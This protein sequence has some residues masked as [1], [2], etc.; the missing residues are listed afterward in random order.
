M[1]T[2]PDAVALLSK[3]HTE[4]VYRGRTMWVM[5]LVVLLGTL[6]LGCMRKPQN[7]Q[8]Q[9]PNVDLSTPL[10]DIRTAI[11]NQ[12]W[13]KAD[14]YSDAVLQRYG[15]D[16]EAILLVAQVAHFNH[17]LEQSADLLLRAVQLE[18]YRNESRVKQCVVALV[19]VGKLFDAIDLLDEAVRTQ[20]DQ[21]ETRRLLFDLCMGSEMR[22]RGLEHGHYLFANAN[23]I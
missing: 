1:K 5:A 22:Q 14:L 13:T 2:E 21:L 8:P 3:P 4:R 23:S 6:P 20:P 10:S 15:E 17:R 12:H 16:V 11:Q 7:D 9:N 19:G 18:N